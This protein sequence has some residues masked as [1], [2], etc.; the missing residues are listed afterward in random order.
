MELFNTKLPLKDENARHLFLS[1]EW[2][3]GFKS[4][5]RVYF[6]SFHINTHNFF[7]FLHLASKTLKINEIIRKAMMFQANNSCK[8]KSISPVHVQILLLLFSSFH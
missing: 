4:Y 8:I 2:K 6:D 3:M 1:A 5:E 7:L